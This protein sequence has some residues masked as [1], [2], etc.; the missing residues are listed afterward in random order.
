MWRTSW[1]CQ[2][3]DTRNRRHDGIPCDRRCFFL[4]QRMLPAMDLIPADRDE[5]GLPA[6]V[7]WKFVNPAELVKQ[8]EKWSR[9]YQQ[10]F[11][12]R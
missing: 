9:L 2:T 1:H 5:K 11:S 6:G 12:A 3:A 7:D 4:A 10:V 8:S